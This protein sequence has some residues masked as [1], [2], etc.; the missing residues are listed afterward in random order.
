ME[1]GEG[2]GSARKGGGGESAERE[3][4]RGALGERKWER[5]GLEGAMEVKGVVFTC[6]HSSQ[7]GERPLC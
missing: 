2:K 6:E 7:S 3:R 5:K 4:K 1:Q